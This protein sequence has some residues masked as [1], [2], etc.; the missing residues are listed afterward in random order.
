MDISLDLQV[1]KT[2]LLKTTMST[3]YFVLQHVYMCIVGEQVHLKPL[4]PT[5]DFKT[6]DP[7]TYVKY[8]ELW[9]ALQGWKGG[10]I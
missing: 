2:F 6:T 4:A 5:R 1:T 10:L 7:L 9:A 8:S 3:A